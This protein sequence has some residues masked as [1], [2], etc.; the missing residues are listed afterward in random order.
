[1]SCLHSETFSQKTLH[2][3]SKWQTLLRMLSQ[4]DGSVT[5]MSGEDIDSRHSL[6]ERDYV[7]GGMSAAIQ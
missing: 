1:M 7:S 3:F 4:K 5:M 6:N 2:C